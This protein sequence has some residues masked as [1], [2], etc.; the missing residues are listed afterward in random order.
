[1]VGHPHSLKKILAFGK[2]LDYVHSCMRLAQAVKSIRAFNRFYTNIIGV[3]DRHILDSPYSLTE[4]RILYEI[5]HHK[6][7]TARKIKNFLRIDEGYLSRTIDKLIKQGLIM[8][9]QS[10]EDAREFVLSLSR[11]GKSEILILN[12]LSEK[13]VGLM[14]GHLRNFEIDELVTLVCKMRELLTRDRKGDGKDSRD[15]YQI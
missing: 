2:C 6:N 1:M 12:K 3:I 7:P 5:H 13:E 9:K 4:V 14:I 11:K 8:R 15:Y 10:P